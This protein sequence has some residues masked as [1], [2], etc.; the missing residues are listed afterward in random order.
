MT[1]KIATTRLTEVKTTRE[2][3]D[4]LKPRGR[5]AGKKAPNKTFSKGANFETPYLGRIYSE[6]SQASYRN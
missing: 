5:K 2:S 6:I 4:E 1:H 3:E